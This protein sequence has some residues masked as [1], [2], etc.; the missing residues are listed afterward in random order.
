MALFVF[1]PL[2]WPLLAGPGRAKTK[3]EG[4]M[5][6]KIMLEESQMPRQWYNIVADL[7]SPLP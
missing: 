6:T 1:W 7:P 4:V 5:D 3:K 2:I